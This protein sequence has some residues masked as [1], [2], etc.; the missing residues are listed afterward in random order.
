V[1][2][3]RVPFFLLGTVICLLLVPVAEPELRWV[4]EATAAVYAVLAALVALD[5][6]GRRGRR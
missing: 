5:V 1:K 3:R 4:P 2:D 6:R